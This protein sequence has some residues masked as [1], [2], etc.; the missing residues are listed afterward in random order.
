MVVVIGVGVVNMADSKRRMNYLEDKAQSHYENN[1]I[2]AYMQEFFVAVSRDKYITKPVYKASSNDEKYKFDF[3]IYHSKLISKNEDANVLVLALSNL[4]IKIDP[5]DIDN[6]NKDNNLIKIV[7]NIEFANFKGKST[8]T[9]KGMQFPLE[10]S[11]PMDVF[12]PMEFLMATNDSGQSFF[13]QEGK[14]T[15]SIRTITFEIEDNTSTIKNA[16]P[17]ITK[18]AQFTSSTY[19]EKLDVIDILEKSPEGILKSTKFN[20]NAYRYSLDDVYANDSLDNITMIDTD[21]LKPYSTVMTKYTVIYVSVIVVISSLLFFYK[22]VLNYIRS[23][24]Q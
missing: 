13:S 12:V 1:D 14:L 19:E 8:Y 15:D 2:D 20:G 16:P 22:P 6:Y 9:L 3:S 5:V 21:L 18:F 7:I 24:N 23:K 4:D 17:L 11:V 10:S